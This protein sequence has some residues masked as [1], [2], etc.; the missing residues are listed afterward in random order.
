[1]PESHYS[2]ACHDVLGLRSNDPGFKWSFG[3]R[4]PA[5]NQEEYDRC[6]L[7]L[8]F[9]VKSDWAVESNSTTEKYHYFSGHSNE[10]ALDYV[11]PFLPGATLKMRI[12]GLL[13][14]QPSVCVNSAYYRFV[15]H[16]FM[17]LHSAGYV[18]S[19][20]ST[21]LLLHRGIAPLHCSC[22]RV[23]DATV[24]IAAP[25][26]TGKTLT[27]MMACMEHDAEFI[28]EDL[29][30]TDGE[31]VFSVPWTSTF[32]YYNKID[33]SWRSRFANSLKDTFAPLALLPSGAPRPVTKFINHERLVSRSPVTHLVVL[34]RGEESVSTLQTDEAYRLVR[35]LNRYEFN[36]NRVPAAVAYEYFNPALDLAGACSAE[37]RILQQ[38]V[39]RVEN[40]LIVRSPD[41]TRYA[42]LLIEQLR[43]DARQ[44][45][46]LAS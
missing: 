39:D 32:R 30:F 37:D 42:G 5:A 18:L 40:R 31:N 2:I 6:L 21:L 46:R 19:D 7:R 34:Q 20:L 44:P 14:D 29:A 12:E 36:Y 43:Q 26:N 28:A 15:T 3:M 22:F 10:D 13:S 11:R 25:P 45:M 41:A 27:A 24:L 16:R 23:G 9:R 17:N 4:A 33:R 8:D 38:L 1:M 35:N